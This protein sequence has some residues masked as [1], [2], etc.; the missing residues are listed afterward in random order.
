MKI[1]YTASNFTDKTIGII[2]IANEIVR[3]YE[4]QGFSLTLRQLYY[5]FV[6]RDYVANTEQSYK[7][8]GN[9][10]S[11]G[12]RA[13]LID[14]DAIED[15]TRYVRRISH[16]DTPSD[17][18]ESAM[19]SFK[20]S[21][22]ENQPINPEVWIEKDALIGVISGV[23]GN[24]D[25]P[26]FSCRGYVSD[27]EMWRAGRRVYDN[28]LHGKT[29]L[30][31]HLGDHDPSGV[32]MTRD[33]ES[34]LALFGELEPFE[35]RRIALNIDQIDQYK[36]PPNPTK[37]TDSRAS[38]YISKYGRNSW[39][40]DAL[41]PAVLAELISDE[42]GSEIDWDIWEDTVVR[43]KQHKSELQSVA[44]NWKK[45]IKWLN[46]GGSASN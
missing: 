29:T 24:Y 15:R 3:E 12:R 42:L 43:E 27:S 17:V 38:G 5:Q 2:E 11:D 31:L 25:V 7:R 22:W 46:N 45:I 8:L 6:A 37:L 40:L 44:T 10:I 30:I 33:I 32:D 34:R 39:E 1:A 35:V 23:C 26:Y 21:M 20:L 14:W 18:M 36:P 19:R 41:S 16:W 9:I 13:G 4:E 28:S